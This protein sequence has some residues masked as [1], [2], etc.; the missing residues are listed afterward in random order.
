M[1]QHE[2]IANATDQPILLITN[3]SAELEKAGS[4]NAE[5]DTNKKDSNEQSNKW[6]VFAILA[7]GIFMATLDSSIVNISLPTIAHFFGVPLSGA[8]EWVIIAYLVVTAAVL[9]T[10]GRLADMIG[11]KPIWVAG[12]I[13]FITGSAICGAAPSLA[14]LIAARGLQGLGGA[15]I[16]AIS[17]AMLT[18]AF[19]AHERGRALG[20]NAVFVALG[21]STGPT[22]GGI[23]TTN[24][25]WR[26][27]F[28]VN[29]P[30]G[31]VG[32]VAS[33]LILKEKMRWNRGKFDPAG[34]I[35]LALGLVAITLG[36]SFGQ[37]WGW[38]SPLLIGCLATGFIALILLYIVEKR[39]A[40][41]I[42]NL[43]LLHNRV[44][45]S[46]TLS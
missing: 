4:A 15:L 18:T 30:I 12:L 36:L 41:P 23:I 31:I 33:L 16:M 22:L 1:K 39:V 34:A 42:I 3:A 35:L 32:I 6:V 40:D 25:S 26:W 8:V 5:T 14:I 7:V 28:Y 10:A 43:S 11:R 19:P 13:I 21:V 2:T 27:I 38:N 17:P 44:F 9:L 24:L 37:E 29:V 20:I 45:L 46:A